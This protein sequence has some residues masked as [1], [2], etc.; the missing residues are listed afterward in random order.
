M[1][2]EGRLAVLSA[3]ETG[4]IDQQLPDEVVSLPTGLMQA[5]I[6]GI[7][8]SLWPVNDVS[9]LMLIA[10]FYDIWR[11]D[12]VQPPE[13]LQQAQRWVR[14]STNEEKMRYL[15]VVL[16]EL[17]VSTSPEL[18][19]LAQYPSERAFSEPMYWAAFTYVGV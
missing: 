9:T 14:D 1:R 8:L 19:H 6:P 4:V 18:E 10:R 16:P 5:G 13:A 11:L 2:L 7:V 12:G 17:D 15:K 3:C